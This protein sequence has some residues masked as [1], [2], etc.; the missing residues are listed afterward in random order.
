MTR[1]PCRPRVRNETCTVKEKTSA[2]EFLFPAVM[3]TFPIMLH[4]AVRAG[5]TV[6]P[7]L[8]KETCNPAMLNPDGLKVEVDE[9]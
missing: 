5:L 8:L 2:V 9:R 1:L 3:H 4:T 6:S 7:K